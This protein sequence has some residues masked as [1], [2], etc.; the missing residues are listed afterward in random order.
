MEQEK[1]YREWEWS[2]DDFCVHI[3][4]TWAAEQTQKDANYHKYQ[5][6]LSEL[7]SQMESLLGENSALIQEFIEAK[8]LADSCSDLPNYL[9]GYRDCLFLLHKLELI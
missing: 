3:L 2:F 6:R 4:N 1:F 7:E 9:Q 5:K 8:N